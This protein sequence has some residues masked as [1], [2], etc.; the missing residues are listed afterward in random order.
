[1]HS[2]GDSFRT[3]LS[4]LKTKGASEAEIKDVMNQLSGVDPVE[5]EKTIKFNAKAKKEEEEFEENER[6]RLEER[7]KAKENMTEEELKKQKR[8]EKEELDFLSALEKAEPAKNRRAVPGA[9]KKA[10]KIGALTFLASILIFSFLA[11]Y[12]R[13]SAYGAFGVVYGL[14]VGLVIKNVVKSKTHKIGVI[15]AVV[16]GVGSIYIIPLTS[17]SA[18]HSRSHWSENYIDFWGF[19]MQGNFLEWMI[20]SMSI[21]SLI[22]IVGAAYAG[23]KVVVGKKVA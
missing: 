17:L 8:L 23:Y 16:S 1:M 19:M 10:W 14:L 13:E 5:K 22:A 15:A 11:H 3:I 7:E 4:Y 20:M 9:D 18:F 2:R 21:F 12:M 6:K